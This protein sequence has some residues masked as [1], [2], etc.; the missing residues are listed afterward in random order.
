MHN[1]SQ[2]QLRLLEQLYT[3]HSPSIKGGEVK[4]KEFI[5]NYIDSF[6]K[7]NMTLRED[8]YGNLYISKRSNKPRD[9]TPCVVAHLD[10]VQTTHP[11]DF[12]VR[13]S[14]DNTILF[15][16]SESLHKQCGL[17]ADDKNGIFIALE[18]LK[19]FE[20][21][22]VAFFVLEEVGGIGSSQADLTF[23][24]DV[25]YIIQPDRRDNSDLITNISGTPICSDAFKNKL[26]SLK[27]YNYKE[28]MG[29]FTDVLNLVDRGVGVSCINLSCGYYLPHHDEEYT[30]LSDLQRCLTFVKRIIRKVKDR[31]EFTPPISKYSD[32]YDPYSFYYDEWG[33]YAD[34]KWYSDERVADVFPDFYERMEQLGRKRM[35]DLSEE[36]RYYL[37]TLDDQKWD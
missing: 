14:E 22:K 15:G 29:I 1:V 26:F 9:Y 3:I 37:N 20:D 17:G 21:I 28:E 23:F 35:N 34:S 30:C 25:A 27:H 19:E 12:E 6:N 7:G 16:W 31:Y 36:E 4:L 24:K 32:Y 33:D 10:Q 18:C 11:D 8:M 13:L 2:K 5:R